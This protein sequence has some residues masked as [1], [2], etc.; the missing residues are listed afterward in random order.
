MKLSEALEIEKAAFERRMEIRKTKGHD[1]ANKDVLANFKA[2]AAVY[3]ALKDYDMEID[4]TTAHGVA[5]WYQ[6]LKILRRLNL[7]KKGVTPKNES[8]EDTIDDNSNYL[9]LERECFIDYHREKSKKQEN[10]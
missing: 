10:L 1:Y 2:S 6:I 5:M 7:Y 4:L 8:L 9:D 3:K